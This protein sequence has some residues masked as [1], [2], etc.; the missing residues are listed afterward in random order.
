[1]ILTVFTLT[2]QADGLT[3]GNVA[4]DVYCLPRAFAAGCCDWE[5]D[6]AHEWKDKHNLWL[7]EHPGVSLPHKSQGSEDPGR[8]LEGTLVRLVIISKLP[9]KN[10]APVLG[11]SYDI[12]NVEHP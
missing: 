12:A 5:R 9:D 2:V 4:K 1:M 10:V 6:P 11:A 7:I 3:A 8:T